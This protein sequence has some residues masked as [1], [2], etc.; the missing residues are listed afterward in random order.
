MAMVV[1]H[2]SATQMSMFARCQ[3]AWMFRYVWGKIVKPKS[4]MMRGRCVHKAVATDY[5]QKVQ[6]KVSLP[7]EDVLD[8]YS[9]VYEAEAVDVAWK[10]GEDKG[11]VKD[12][13]VRV[14]VKYHEEVVVNTQ[15]VDVEQSF[16]MNIAWVQDDEDKIV[17]YKGVLDVMDNGGG[18]TDLKTC[19]QTPKVPGND[20]QSQLVG[21]AIGKEAMGDQPTS[22]H[23]HYLV[24]LKTPKIVQFDVPVTDSRKKFFLTQ[25]PRIVTAMEGENYYP[26]RGNRWC[27]ES[28]CGYHSLCLEEFGG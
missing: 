27:S 15:P 23:L 9:D 17:K 26:N 13:G 24:A 4:A 21:Y 3:V 6:S 10:E 28:S 8:A 22:A 19:G 1:D 2:I 25:I 12:G 16:S 11:V 5:T 14:L 20:A 7:I 18:I